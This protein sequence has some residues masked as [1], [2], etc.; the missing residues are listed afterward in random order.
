MANSLYNS[1]RA[2]FL[3]GSYNW[4]TDVIKVALV[5]TA[6]YTVDLATH[7]QFS[8][9]IAA[10]AV[11]AVQTLSTKVITTPDGAADA[12]DTTFPAVAAGVSLEAIVIYKEIAAGTDE[13]LIAYIDTATGLPITTNG[14]DIIITWDNGIN[15]IFRL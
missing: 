15:K 10:G 7:T 4:E 1:A 8:T 3:R 11:N 2:G 12:A 9:N 6:Q 13:P 14:G 5:D